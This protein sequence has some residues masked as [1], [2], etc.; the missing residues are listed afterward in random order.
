LFLF[1][2]FRVEKEGSWAEDEYV[3]WKCHVAYRMVITPPGGSDECSDVYLELLAGEVA[4]VVVV[5]AVLMVV[6]REKRATTPE[7]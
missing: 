6:L 2:P 1:P 4:V 3:G 7:P 5:A